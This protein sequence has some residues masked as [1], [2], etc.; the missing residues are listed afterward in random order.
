MTAVFTPTPLRVSVQHYAKMIE[1]GALTKH[2]RVELLEGE[3]LRMAPI[4]KEHTAITAHLHERFVL[5]LAGAATVIGS[6][7][8]NLGERSAPQPDLMLLKRRADFYRARLPE[9]TD[10]LVLIEV[11]DSS[12]ALDQGRKLEVYAENGIPEYWIVD[13]GG[14]RVVTYLEPV[15]QGYARRLEFTVDESVTPQAFPN[16]TLKVREIFE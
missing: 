9:A 10:I 1:T 14:K 2:D 3:I 16:L 6:G 7:T 13:V 4:G 5:L 11:S 15:G 12:L 8:V